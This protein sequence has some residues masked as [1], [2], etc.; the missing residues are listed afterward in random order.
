[1]ADTNI[2]CTHCKRITN[3]SDFEKNGKL[4]KT[5]IKCR[6]IKIKSI[7]KNKCQHGKRRGRCVE[8]GGGTICIHLKRRECCLIC[9]GGSLCIHKKQKT[10][11]KIC[12][13][14]IKITI[15]NMISNS[16]TKDKKYN[17][18]DI[19]NFIDKCFLKNL[20]EDCNDKCYYCKC[21]LQYIIYQ[22]NLATIERIDNSIG[23]IKS[24]VVIACH[25]CN[26]SRVGDKLI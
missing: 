18:Y 9:G 21:D 15:Q 8:C 23:H 11:C 13:D 2:K 25:H 14:K 20:I 17:I 3:I 4:L 26:L 12:G 24:N 10:H 19:V 7:T 1:M 5:C 16:K 22:N 6:M